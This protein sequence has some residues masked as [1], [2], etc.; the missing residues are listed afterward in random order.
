MSQDW[1][2]S[3]D[4]G[5]FND[6]FALDNT[7][8]LPP[9]Y[10]E[11]FIPDLGESWLSAFV[12]NEVLPDPINSS[13]RQLNADVTSFDNDAGCKAGVDIGTPSLDE[14]ADLRGPSSNH[15]DCL[16]DLLNYGV[17][18]RVNMVA[19]DEEEA[20]VDSTHRSCSS[21]ARRSLS[22]LSNKSHLARSGQQASAKCLTSD[23]PKFKRTKISNEVRIVLDAHFSGSAY[24][25]DVELALLSRKTGL[26]VSVIK[27]WFVNARSRKT[28]PEG[29]KVHDP[30]TELSIPA[31]RHPILTVRAFEGC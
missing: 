4:V 27:R 24:P 13:L 14:P 18:D 2:A 7:E 1:E 5:I 26:P 16:L 21:P 31:R 20:K 17:P 10:D 22:D 23:K 30:V 12:A 19:K 8:E 3:T 11:G 25:T 28:M 15:S 9:R 29:K 6:W